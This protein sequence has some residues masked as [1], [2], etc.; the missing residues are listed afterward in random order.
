MNG[1]TTLIMQGTEV[2]LK[3][4]MYSFRVI[5]ER[6]EKSKGYDEG[7]L[8]ETGISI[9]LYAGY[10]ND[11]VLKDAEPQIT[12]EDFADFV[13]SALINGDKDQITKA[14]ECWTQSQFMQTTIAKN[15]AQ[16]EEAAKKK[17]TGTKLKKQ[18][19][20]K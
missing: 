18:P 3:F 16:Q 12:L 15:K 20:V 17:S 14:I 7:T 19:S 11:R 13:E 1:R 10:L 4:G 6:L 8:N 9:V 2:S 5:S